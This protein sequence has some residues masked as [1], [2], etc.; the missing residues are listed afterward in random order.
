ME[1]REG[2][3][4]F[5][6]DTTRITH[7]KKICV[8]VFVLFAAFPFSCAQLTDSPS[9]IYN[10]ASTRHYQLAH[11]EVE[12]M[13]EE[14]IS[15]IG[16]F[17]RVINADPQGKWADD[18]QYAITSCWMWMAQNIGS[19]DRDETGPTEATP[20]ERAIDSLKT[21]LDEYPGSQYAAEANYW[22]GNCYKVLGEELRAITYYQTVIRNYL[23]HPIS[24]DAQFQLGG[25]YER[26]QH[27]SSAMATY[28]ALAQRS[29]KAKI[30]A[31]TEKRIADLQRKQ[32]APSARVANASEQRKAD[33]QKPPAV[34]RSGPQVKTG[35]VDTSTPTHSS[36]QKQP[37][38]PSKTGDGKAHE[39]DHADAGVSVSNTLSPPSPRVQRK[40]KEAVGA[41]GTDL[42]PFDTLTKPISQK[43]SKLAGKAKNRTKIAMPPSNQRIGF[44]KV[45]VIDPGHGGKDPGALSR[46]WGHEKKVVLDISKALRDILI[47][48][49]YR[50]RLTRERDTYLP[51]EERTKLATK[52]NANL[53]I[54]IHANAFASRRVSGIETYYLAS[55][56]DESS[57]MTVARENTGSK[58]SIRKLNQMKILENSSAKNIRLAKSVHG[59]LIRATKAK[60]RGVR[61]APFR[62]LNGTEVPSILIEVGF[63]T[64]P[65]EAKKLAT[66]TYQRQIATAIVKGIEEYLTGPPSTVTNGKGRTGG[67]RRK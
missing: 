16:E 28:Q 58:H 9:S 2:I 41:N 24:E 30:V 49:G 62:V 3:L 57:K 42:A 54:S 45:I 40:P 51:L 1:E 32:V 44:N 59:H 26:Q 46:L 53:F 56:S 61:H 23:E 66:K 25:I 21:L 18:A 4:R 20:T 52:K 22:L 8:S 64:N 11:D 6:F 13:A 35:K 39:F 14:W 5:T 34:T 50:V 48:K 17:Q 65:K 37:D 43:L 27:F 63:M 29:K 36:S 10:A 12:V 33:E 19:H 15:L 55:A 31:D 47:K 67:K 7:L 38:R 60:D